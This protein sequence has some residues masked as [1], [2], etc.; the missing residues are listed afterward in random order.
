MKN[1]LC[2]ALL[3]LAVACQASNTQAPAVERD[4]NLAK[5]LYVGEVSLMPSAEAIVVSNANGLLAVQA[6]LKNGQPHERKLEYQWEWLDERGIVVS[7]PSTTWI[8]IA[9]RPGELASVQGTAP[10]PACVDF[11]LKLS[12]LPN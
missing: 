11:R 3:G 6:R 8:P 4:P 5:V 7:S 12:K 10:T 9:I 2:I 1:L